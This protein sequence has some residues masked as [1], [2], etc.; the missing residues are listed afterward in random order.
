MKKRFKYSTEY[1]PMY[2][3][4]VGEP[5]WGARGG[6][7]ARVRRGWG[8]AGREGGL[9]GGPEVATTDCCARRP[10]ELSQG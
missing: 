1:Q 3:P 10:V 7:V 6:G 5:T 8:W 9:L 4:T 2:Q